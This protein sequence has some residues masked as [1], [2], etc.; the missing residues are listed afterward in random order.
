MVRGVPSTY[1]VSDDSASAAPAFIQWASA[2]IGA[3][4]RLLTSALIGRVGGPKRSGATPGSGPIQR[5][6]K[7]HGM[8]L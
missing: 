4:F 2:L 7:R 8:H 1:G 6:V 5:A 3:P